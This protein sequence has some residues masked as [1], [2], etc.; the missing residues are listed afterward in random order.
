MQLISN[1]KTW[2]R[3]IFAG[4]L[5][6]ALATLFMMGMAVWLPAGVAGV[7][8]I[9]VPIALFPLIWVVVFFYACVEPKMSRMAV[10]IVGSMLLHV[11]LLWWHF[12]NI[13]GS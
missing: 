9:V 8:N 1:K 2:L 5:T 10:V 4:P 6:L 3:W 12:T 13:G 11:A 7:N